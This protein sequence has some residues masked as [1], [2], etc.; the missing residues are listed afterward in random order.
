MEYWTMEGYTVGL[1]KGVAVVADRIKLGCEE[2]AGTVLPGEHFEGASDGN[3]EGVGTGEGDPLG[4]S[5]E[6]EFGKI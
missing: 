5:Q 2:G 4:I 1:L 6:T 3:L